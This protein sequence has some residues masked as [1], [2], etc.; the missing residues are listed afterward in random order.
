V[1]RID[2]SREAR[3]IDRLV[4][5]CDPQPGAFAELRG[6]RVRLFDGHLA[7]GRGG[8]PGEVV[9]IEG[10]RL[11]VAARGGALSLGRVRIGEGAK[12]AAG[13][14]GLTPGDRLR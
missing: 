10:G 8:E 4:R 13:E 12:L 7:P 5:G 3:E 9:A 11:L 1:A 2:W 6:E 14:G